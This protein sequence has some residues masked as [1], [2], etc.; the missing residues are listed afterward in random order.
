MTESEPGRRPGVVVRL[1]RATTTADVLAGLGIASLFI[2]GL[3]A[4]PPA[5]FIVLGLALLLVARYG[6]EG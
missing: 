3:L 2:G 1:R 4:W 5:G 6:A